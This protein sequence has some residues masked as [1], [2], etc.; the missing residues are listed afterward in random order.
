MEASSMTTEISPGIHWREWTD[1]ILEQAGKEDKLILLSIGAKWCHW[2]HVMDRTTYSNPE[3]IEL[4]NEHFLPVKVDA[5][6]RP[7]IQ[8]KYLL[9]GWPTT[10]FLVPDGRILTG[11]TF[12]PTE[13]MILKLREVDGLWHEQKPTITK[14]VTSMA[15]E[16]EY[17]RNQAEV[18]VGSLDGEVMRALVATLKGAFDQEY[19]G[20]SYEPKFPYPEAVELL[21]LRYRSTGDKELLSMALKTL[22]AQLGIYDPVW[23]GFYRY[24]IKADWSQPHYEKLLYVQANLMNNYLEAYQVTGNDKYAETAAGIKSYVMRFLADTEKGGFYASQDAD[25][26]SHDFGVEMILGED[27]FPKSESERLAIGIPDVDKTIFTDWNGMMISAFFRLYHVLGDVHARDFAVKTLDRVLAENACTDQMC[28]F[29]DGDKSFLG[30]LSDQVHFAQ[31]LLDAYQTTG[32][33]NYLTE[34]ENL[35]SFMIVKLQD[36]VDGGFYL[37]QFDPHAMGEHLERRKPFDENAAAAKLLVKLNYLTAYEPYR[38][39]A[40]RTLRAICYP[41]ITENIV[42]AAFGV[43]LDLFI[44]NPI[45]IVLVGKRDDPEMQSML[46]ASLH[47]YDPRKLVQVLDPE[48]GPTTIG[49][50][51]YTATETP[52]AYV[53]IQNTCAP[54]ATNTEELNIL[55]EDIIAGIPTSST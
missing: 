48:C 25:V 13:A 30:L 36:V 22:D 43:A 32:Y 2:C 35:V 28:H 40:A 18:P 19:G 15:A 29:L 33:R 54:P 23:G 49:E 8:D 37:Q 46:A 9:G 10:V 47:T 34:A 12:I 3:V 38:K 6:R 27:Y 42:G 53:C 5:D 55:L 14:H 45:H 7:D 52:V 16:A 26:H 44:S 51:T 41:Q 20:F 39:H 4:A 50:V 21:F 1:D 17:D 11:S 31:A 24:S